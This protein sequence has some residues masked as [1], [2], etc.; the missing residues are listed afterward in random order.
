MHFRRDALAL[1]RSGAEHD[2]ERNPAQKP[3]I[4]HD[5]SL[6]DLRG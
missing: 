2:G 3:F 1:H 4:P 6:S 5:T